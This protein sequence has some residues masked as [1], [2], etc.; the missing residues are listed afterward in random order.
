VRGSIGA[1]RECPFIEGRKRI[2]AVWK[3]L[4]WPRMAILG[5]RTFLSLYLW[6]DPPGRCWRGGGTGGENAQPIVRNVSTTIDRYELTI[7][8]DQQ[9]QKLSNNLFGMDRLTTDSQRGTLSTWHCLMTSGR[10]SRR[11]N[12]NSRSTPSIRPLQEASV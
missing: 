12:T 10:R 6:I 4:I 3:F 9:K 11:G 5:A 1:G 2:P 7:Q 8:Q